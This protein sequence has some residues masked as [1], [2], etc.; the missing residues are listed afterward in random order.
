MEERKPDVY[1]YYITVSKVERY[2][3]HEYYEDAIEVPCGRASR[4]MYL[5]TY[6]PLEGTI[7]AAKEQV[8]KAI[9]G[10]EENADR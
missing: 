3:D 2:E 6:V 10:I 7:Q 8:E 9:R 1:G 5:E 4:V